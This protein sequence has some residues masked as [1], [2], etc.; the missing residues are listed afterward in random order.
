MAGHDRNSTTDNTAARAAA[1]V[2][3]EYGNFIRAV[4]RFQASNEFIE[5][6]LF[7]E[8][9]LLLVAKPLPVNIY[10]IKSYLYRAVTN[11]VIESARRRA[12]QERYLKK[13]VEEIRITVNTATPQSAIIK[14]EETE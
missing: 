11:A 5:E 2:F 13:H 10:N 12:R 6:D 14:T 7:Q 3:A 9:F 4:I 8:F 1:A